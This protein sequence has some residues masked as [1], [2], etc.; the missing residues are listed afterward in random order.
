MQLIAGDCDLKVRYLEE[1]ISHLSDINSNWKFTPIPV[2]PNHLKQLKHQSRAKTIEILI[3]Q[4]PHGIELCK[5]NIADFIN[6]ARIIMEKG[7]LCHA[8]VSFEFALEEYGKIMMLKEALANSVVKDKIVVSKDFFKH[9]RKCEKAIEKLGEEFKSVYDM[10]W[11]LREM[12]GLYPL[13]FGT[14]TSHKTRTDCAFVGYRNDEFVIG[15]PIDPE[16]IIKLINL[17]EEKT[18]LK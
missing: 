7:R 3:T 10:N 8:Y 1:S 18:R 9:N 17:L 16:K 14:K 13:W 6:D 4:V 11:F 2:T 12:L 15:A 5:Q